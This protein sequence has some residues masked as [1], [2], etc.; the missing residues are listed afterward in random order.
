MEEDN[1]CCDPTESD[2]VD[3]TSSSDESRG[4]VVW[5]DEDSDVETVEWAT[6]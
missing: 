2:D 5:V 4:G 3:V 1:D 6:G